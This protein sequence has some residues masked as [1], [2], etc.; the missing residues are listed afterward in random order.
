MAKRDYYEV[1][2]VSKGADEQELKKAYRKQA[3]KYHPDRNK[4]DK[5]AE[6]KF[7]EVQEAYE[8]LSDPQKKA[9]YDQYGHSAF[10]GG[11]QQG[12]GG[13]GGQGFGGFEDLGDIFGSMFG[14]AFGGGFGGRS[15]G[16]RVSQGSDLRYNI[17]LT[18]KEAAF[19]TEKE[20]KY[21]RKGKCKTCKGSGAEPGHN[22]KTCDKCNGNGRISVQQR[23]IFGITQTVQECDKCHGTGLESEV[24]T[25]T[26]K[27]P[28]GVDNG[29]RMVVRDGGD[30][31]EK[32]GLFG[33]LYLFFSIKKHPI[34]TR[35]GNDI[36][37]QVPVN[38]TTATL[39]GEIE[40]PT[41]DGKM[42]IK[43]AEGT[44]SGKVLRLKDKGIKNG[45]Y[46]GSEIIEIKVETPTN[47]NTKQKE[48][49]KKFEESLGEKNYKEAKS[50]LDKVK[51]FFS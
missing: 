25:R 9:A 12:G 51:K 22:M 6:E 18:L 43:I 7:K 33:D 34:F 17:E 50:F 19:G 14:D 30:A 46:R 48:L 20:I 39:G 13:F 27:I 28:A 24:I 16:P 32:D 26:I 38:I 36:Y 45:S 40:V 37:C 49:L 2:G 8:I 44:Q 23:T 35:D 15:R 3:M 11:Y 4:D 42:K 41:L 5:E 21:K 10:E 31:G 47:L 1:L 29:Q